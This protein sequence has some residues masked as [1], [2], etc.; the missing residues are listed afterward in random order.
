VAQYDSIVVGLGGAGSSVAYHLARSGL[1]VLGLEQFGPVHAH[2]SSHGRSRIFR[3]AY[4][5]GTAYVPLVQR[6]QQL[7]YL[8]QETSGEKVIHKTGGLVI[9][10]PSTRLV[11][12]AIRTAETCSLQHEVLIPE[13]VRKRYPQFALAPDEVALWDPDAGVLFPENCIRSHASGAVDAGAELHYGEKVREW[14]ATPDTI[15]VRTPVGEYRAKFLVLT[16]GSW[17]SGLADD[18]KLPLTIERQFM[19][20]FPPSD[21]SL[22]SPSRMP[23]FLWDRAPSVETYGVPDFGDGVKIGSWLGKFSPTPEEADRVFRESDAV[24]VRRFVAESMMGLVPRESES[25]SCLYTNA[26]DHNFL[27][28]PH[29]HHSNVVV[30]SA[31]SG[32]GFKFTSAIGEAVARLVRQEKTGF[33]LSLFDPGRFL[34][35]SP[36]TDQRNQSMRTS[37]DPGGNR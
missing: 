8:L 18:L 31:C 7:W 33:D 32:H 9:G 35:A 3:T 19:L 21:L 25:T 26:P 15:S 29:P 6:A 4:S 10:R 37:N 23:V 16:A 20:W 12:G 28:G 2:G 27:L 11:S 1:S 13:E 36:S 30:V 34:R 22:V 14:S 5:E 24:P 17:T